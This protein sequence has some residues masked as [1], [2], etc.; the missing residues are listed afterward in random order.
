MHTASERMRRRRRNRLL[1]VSAVAAA[2]CGTLATGCKPNKRYDLIEAELRTKDKQLAE[3]QA[4]LA[5]SRNLNRAY[6][7]S[8]GLPGDYMAPPAAL[9]S[10]AGSSYPIREISLGRGTGGVDD[11]GLPGDETLMLVVVPRDADKSEVKVA[12]RLQV[13]AWEINPQGIKSPIGSWDIPADRLRTTWR[14]GLMNTGYFVSVPWQTYPTT[15]R[16]RVAV[17]L[18]TT[19]GGTFETDRDISVRP[20]VQALPRAS[21]PVMQQPAPIPGSPP[22]VPG[23]E[24]LYPTNPPAG[25]PSTLPPG[26]EE[27]PPPM[28]VGLLP[29][30][31]N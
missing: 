17:R 7:Q 10:G 16:V 18:T 14:N 21:V 5:Q 3:A 1:A 30:I 2:F 15:D 19:D 28:R 12:G 11:D 20:L 4:A 27:L 22:P 23:R 26:T 6:E 24:P 29:P 8:R 31:A 9:T 13:L 25:V